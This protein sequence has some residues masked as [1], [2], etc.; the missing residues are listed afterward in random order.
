VAAIVIVGVK[1]I[2]VGVEA[3]VAVQVAAIVGI[4]VSNFSPRWLRISSSGW[5]QSSNERCRRG[6]SDRYQ[7]LSAG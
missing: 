1:A 5:Q 2:V 4:L 7:T 3:I 6:G